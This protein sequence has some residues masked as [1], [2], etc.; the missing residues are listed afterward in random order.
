LLRKDVSKMLLPRIGI[1]SQ[2]GFIGIKTASAKL[3][4]TP[5]DLELSMRGN[6]GA[7]IQIKSTQSSIRIDHRRAVESVKRES[8]LRNI[9]MRAAEGNSK[10]LE[11]IAR[12][13]REG[14]ELMSIERGGGGENAIQRIARRK[15]DTHTRVVIAAIAPP[16]TSVQ[17]GEVRTWDASEKLQTKWSE[18]KSTQRYTP[19]FVSYSWHVKPS[20]DIFIVPGT[21]TIP[22]SYGRGLRVDKAL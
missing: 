18:G 3:E 22:A 2:L 8:A 15:M 16:E 4:G 11:D 17:M 20:L 12:I 21:E 14:L 5:P 6:A 19:G 10:A 1:H 7:E 9:K 13:A